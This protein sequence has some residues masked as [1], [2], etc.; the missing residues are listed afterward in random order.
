MNQIVEIDWFGQIESFD[1]LQE[2]D[3]SKVACVY[4]TVRFT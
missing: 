2:T 4:I 1:R 3:Q